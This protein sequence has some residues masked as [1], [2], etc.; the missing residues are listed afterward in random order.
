MGGLVATGRAA[1]LAERV[2]GLYHALGLPLLDHGPAGR[3]LS[4]EGE[5]DLSR[6]RLEVK[7]VAGAAAGASFTGSGSL[8]FL[9]ERL[10]LQASAETGRLDFA[11]TL[12]LLILPR[13]GKPVGATQPFASAL[14]D[15]ASLDIDLKSRLAAARAGAGFQASALQGKGRG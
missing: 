1:I 13:D 10:T 11:N 7:S 2:D 15:A 6:E 9:G 5:V 3:V 4:A 8:G 14:V 12:G